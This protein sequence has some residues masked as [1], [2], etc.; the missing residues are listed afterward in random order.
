MSFISSLQSHP[1]RVTL[2]VYK[3][4]SCKSIS[5]RKIKTNYLSLIEQLGK[6]MLYNTSFDHSGPQKYL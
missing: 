2:Y 5:R 1:L 4:Q 3:P 6:K